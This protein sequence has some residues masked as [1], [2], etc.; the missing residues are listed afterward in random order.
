MASWCQ[1]KDTGI[2]FQGST[3]VF[4]IELGEM[5][6]IFRIDWEE[7]MW[8][9]GTG[10]AIYHSDDAITQEELQQSSDRSDPLLNHILLCGW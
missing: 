6:V 5:A 8:R 3:K 7:V 1:G 4:E 9:P 2:L 10:N